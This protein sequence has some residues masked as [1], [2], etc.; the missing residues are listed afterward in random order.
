M[1][2][3]DFAM[4]RQGLTEAR[5]DERGLGLIGCSQVQVFFFKI[6]AEARDALEETAGG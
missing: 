6:R 5:K 2:A 4:D 1:R 3:G